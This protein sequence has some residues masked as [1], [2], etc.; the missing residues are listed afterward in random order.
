MTCCWSA[1][2]SSIRHPTRRLVASQASHPVGH[3]ER[4]ARRC[5]RAHLSFRTLQRGN[6][7]HDAL[8]HTFFAAQRIQ[9]R[10]SFFRR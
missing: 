4:G 5:S 8:R 7:F 2:R 10:P 9:S 6:A 1:S 3:A